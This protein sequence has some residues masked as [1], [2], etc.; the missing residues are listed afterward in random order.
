MTV[1][2]T[3]LA[4]ASDFTGAGRT[5]GQAKTAYSNLNAVVAEIND[6]AFGAFGTTI[7]DG[8]ALTIPVTGDIFSCPSGSTAV[9]SLA[10]A[11]GVH[12]LGRKIWVVFG[13]ARTITHNATTLILPNG[14]NITTYAGLALLFEE[15]SNGNWRLVGSSD[16]CTLAARSLLD[17]SA[18]GAGQIKFPATQNA[19]AD[20]NT[21][22]DYEEGTWTPADGSGAGLTLTGIAGKYTKIGRM[23]H[24]WF[25]LTYPSTANG[26]NAAITGLP[27]TSISGTPYGGGNYSYTDYTS[28]I[29]A[30]INPSAVTFNFTGGGGYRTNAN[31]STK[32]IIGFVFYSA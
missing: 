22:D 21:L 15:D 26:S 11:G 7:A 30:Q 10:Y 14:S 9:T 32:R 2:N 24:A 3:A 12:F 19:S 25:D 5:Q 1:S 29:S 13:S 17:L 6:N 31:L 28:D 4:A 18:S 23:V 20:A 8:A 16:L 27:Y